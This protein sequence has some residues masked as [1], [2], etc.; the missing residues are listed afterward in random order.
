MSHEIQSEVERDDAPKE[1][2]GNGEQQHIHLVH[3]LLIWE[4]RADGRDILGKVVL[5]EVYGILMV[6]IKVLYDI[7]LPR[8]D[9]DVVLRVSQMGCEARAK[10]ASAKDEDLGV[11]RRLGLG[12][13]HRRQKTVVREGRKDWTGPREA[14]QWL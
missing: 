8:P 2:S 4:V 13:D 12:G 9:P 11:A 5:W 7:G 10:V 1:L 14:R 6:L 3:E